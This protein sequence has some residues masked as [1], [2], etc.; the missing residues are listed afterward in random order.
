[1]KLFERGIKLV[2]ESGESSYWQQTDV[3]DVLR[4]IYKQLLT[5]Y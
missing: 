2:R 4:D 5:A 1:M 3:P